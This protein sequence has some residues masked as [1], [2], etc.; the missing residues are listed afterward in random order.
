MDP[1]IFAKLDNIFGFLVIRKVYS[2]YDA[3]AYAVLVLNEVYFLM[4]IHHVEALRDVSLNVV[5]EVH[6]VWLKSN[7]LAAR[8]CENIFFDQSVP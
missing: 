8:Q 4:V 5:A 3:K 2:L 7:Y 6:A 1:G